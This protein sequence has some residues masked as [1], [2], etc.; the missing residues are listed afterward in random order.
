MMT[1]FQSLFCR[2][3]AKE[4]LRFVR[5]SPVSKDTLHALFSFAT[6]PAPRIVKLCCL[7]QVPLGSHGF[8]RKCIFFF[9]T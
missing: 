4:T 9:S 2:S 8:G 7:Q 5:D 3:C 6:I 1:S